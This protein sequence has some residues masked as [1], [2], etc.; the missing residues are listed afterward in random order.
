VSSAAGDRSK[1]TVKK[2]TRN[3]YQKLEVRRRQDAVAKGVAERL[4][5]LR[6]WTRE[7]VTLHTLRHT[8]VSRMIGEGHNDHTVMAFSGHSSTRMLERYTHPTEEHKIGALKS[9]GPM[10][11]R[12]KHALAASTAGIDA[13]RTHIDEP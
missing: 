10:P 12:H 6:A 7:D 4:I 1:E 2:H 11:K 3:T 9:I 5:R 8:A 13:G